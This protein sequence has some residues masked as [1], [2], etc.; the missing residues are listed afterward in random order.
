MLVMVHLTKMVNLKLILVLTF[1]IKVAIAV[2][3]HTQSSG[4]IIV[5]EFLIMNVTPPVTKAQVNGTVDFP[6]PVGCTIRTG[7]GGSLKAIIFNRQH[8]IRP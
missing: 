4:G 3:V 5:S 7:S 6:E 1:I 2:L 8:T